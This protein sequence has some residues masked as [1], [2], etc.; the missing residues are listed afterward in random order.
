MFVIHHYSTVDMSV[1]LLSQHS[2]RF[3]TLSDVIV[4]IL[5]LFLWGWGPKFPGTSFCAHYFESFGVRGNEKK[6]LF[7]TSGG[8]IVNSLVR[9]RDR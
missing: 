8:Q 2:I 6:A 7:C 3:V 1:D 9:L 4:Y 5:F